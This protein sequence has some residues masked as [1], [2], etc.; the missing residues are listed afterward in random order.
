MA[1]QWALRLP[2]GTQATPARRGSRRWSPTVSSRIALRRHLA[3]H[4]TLPCR[5]DG[6]LATFS[7]INT[8]EPNHETPSATAGAACSVFKWLWGWFYGLSNTSSTSM[9]PCPFLDGGRY[10]KEAFQHIRA[11]ETL[12]TWTA[13]RV[14]S[15][16]ATPPSIACDEEVQGRQHKSCTNQGI[17]VVA[18]QCYGGKKAGKG[19]QRFVQRAPA[20]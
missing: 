15:G 10:G 16:A 3:L 4:A 19:R 9:L 5:R 18:G 11:W 6:P 12:T 1:Q 17:E 20:R 13:S 8:I 2:D 7:T 14:S